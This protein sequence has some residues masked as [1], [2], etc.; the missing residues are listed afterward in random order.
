MPMIR[1]R[2]ELIGRR[3]GNGVVIAE[4]GVEII[5]SSTVKGKKYPHQSQ[6]WKLKCDCGN[7]YTSASCYLFRGQGTHCG[8][9]RKE[10]LL[11][12]RFGNAVVIG[13]VGRKIR[14]K[15]SPRLSNVWELQCDCG[16][17]FQTHAEYLTCGGTASCGCHK[18]NFH[19]TY[20]RRSFAQ[21]FNTIKH[22]AKRRGRLVTITK[23]QLENLMDIQSNK[24]RLSGLPIS[25]D[26][27]SA[28]LDRIDNEKDYTLENVQWVHR[29]VNYMKNSLS[30]EEFFSLCGAVSCVIRNNQSDTHHDQI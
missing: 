11:G 6:T 28:S 27:G 3:F 5:G 15:T 4:L 26:D 20:H 21:Y 16:K 17:V 12:K 22:D 13:Y 18:H 19:N 14:G 9:L 10:N 23:E 1:K 24:C 30:Q 25:F 8:C 7:E 2:Y 29:K